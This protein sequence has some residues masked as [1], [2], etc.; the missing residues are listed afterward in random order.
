MDKVKILYIWIDEYKCISKQGFNLDSKYIFDYNNE[1]NTLSVKEN[2]NY[3]KDFF[4]LN[5]NPKS[6]I[7]SITAIVGKNGSGKSTF[8]DVLISICSLRNLDNKIIVYSKN[9]QLF[10]FSS[11]DI[12]VPDNIAEENKGSDLNNKKNNFYLYQNLSLIYINNLFNSLQSIKDLIKVSTNLR[13]LS[14][15]FLLNNDIS[16][17]EPKLQESIQK[18]YISD[19][20]KQLNFIISS[21]ENLQLSIK[22]NYL[23]LYA[24]FISVEDLKLKFKNPIN[25]KI[26][27]EQIIEVYREIIDKIKLL[28]DNKNKFSVKLALYIISQ[29]IL[30]L[31]D[32]NFYQEIDINDINILLNDLLNIVK[33]NENLDLDIFFIEEN[34]V[35]TNNFKQYLINT[36]IS[37]IKAILETGYFLYSQDRKDIYCIIQLEKSKSLLE[38]YKVDP[39]SRN[40]VF[41]D[42]VFYDGSEKTS[43]LH[44]SSGENMYLVF[45]SRIFELFNSEKSLNNNI[46][47]LIDECELALHPEWQR[48][49]IYNLINFIENLNLEKKY[50]FQIVITSHSPFIVSD[51]PDENIII[52]KNKKQSKEIVDSNFIDHKTF[53][54]NISKLFENNFF[55]ENT[56]GYF[57][58]DKITNIIK[59]IES[60]KKTITK[61]KYE[62]LKKIIEKIGEPFI[63]KKLL[64]MLESKKIRVYKG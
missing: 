20:I 58:F 40:L 3:V 39:F 9:N 6:K 59:E 34:N 53:A 41:F 15:N 22:P 14:E 1:N 33:N 52:M 45:F 51:L 60:S 21:S 27:E 37:W 25:I 17:A 10:Y 44:L 54:S 43:L 28:T 18:H 61:V 36:D 62:R 24:N 12:S 5:E 16:K 32:N 35:Q 23:G 26:I 42:W 47:L 19:L 48:K 64:Y 7:N 29:K 2:E 46:L 57:A 11:F 4:S 55:L 50:N 8:I 38:Q 49:F 56:M 13:N 30:L 63:R 31:E